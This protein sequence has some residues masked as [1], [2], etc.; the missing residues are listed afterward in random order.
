MTIGDYE[1]YFN[2]KIEGQFNEGGLSYNFGFGLLRVTQ[3]A[4]YLLYAD[5]NYLKLDLRMVPIPNILFFDKNFESSW[6]DDNDT[7]EGRIILNSVLNSQKQDILKRDENMTDGKPEFM[8]SELNLSG[9]TY[10][11][12]HFAKQYAFEVV[13]GAEALKDIV[14]INGTLHLR[15]P[16]G[17]GETFLTKNDLNKPVTLPNGLTIVLKT[18]TAKGGSIEITGMPKNIKKNYYFR[19]LDKNGE[20]GSQSSNSYTSDDTTVYTFLSE[21]IEKI[22]VLYVNSFVSKDIPFILTKHTDT[23]VTLLPQ[24]TELDAEKKEMVRSYFELQKVLETNDLEKIID[25]PYMA[26]FKDAEPKITPETTT[27]GVHNT[28]PSTV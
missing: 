14:E 5:E 25:S 11:R 21:N 3:N 2:Q 16:V 28:E 13:G 1:P 20:E 24:I 10:I 15:L 8:S 4:P 7:K 22:Q 27:A 9:S 19:L 18:L 26:G 23:P 12:E 6:S 17:A